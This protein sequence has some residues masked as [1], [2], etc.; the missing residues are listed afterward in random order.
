MC[1]ARYITSIALAIIGLQRKDLLAFEHENIELIT[2]SALMSAI[3]DLWNTGL[4]CWYLSRQRSA[5]KQ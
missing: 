1:T 2:A 4:L 5:F 3:I